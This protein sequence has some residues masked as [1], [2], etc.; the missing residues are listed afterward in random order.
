MT[1]RTILLKLRAAIQARSRSDR[2]EQVLL[3]RVS[4]GS[5]VGRFIRYENRKVVLNA[6][7]GGV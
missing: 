6:G 7:R 2:K 4:R 1:R 3:Q 5:R